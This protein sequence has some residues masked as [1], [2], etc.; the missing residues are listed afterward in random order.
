MAGNNYQNG[1]GWNRGGSGNGGSRGYSNQPPQQ[2]YGRPGQA[3]LDLKSIQTELTKK[4][5]DNVS[6]LPPGFNRDRFILN[7]ITFIQ[8][9]L[10]DSKKRENLANVDPG[11]IVAC[12]MKGA[13]LGLDFFNGECYAIP[14]GS[15]MTFQTDYKGEIKLNKMYSK[16]PI[17]DIF[18]KVVREG[19]E[20]YEE[21]SGGEQTIYYRP[22]PFS[23]APLVGAF[24]VVKYK[25]GS[26][27]YESMS[28]E[29]IEK[30]RTTYSKAANSKAWK[31]ST[32]EMYKKT[33]LRRVCKFVD[34]DFTAE[35]RRA[36]EDGGDAQFDDVIT[37]ENRRAIENGGQTVNVFQE[38]PKPAAL[39]EPKARPAAPVVEQKKPEPVKAQTAAAPPDDDF[40]RFEQSYR[41]S[42][43]PPNDDYMIP[44][45]SMEGL[46]FR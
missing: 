29:E 7:C 36:F 24:A 46:P 40:A 27:L 37:V 20:F 28:A 33:V 41:E 10:A 16:N 23:T 13:V 26:M 35:Q 30:V 18:A 43:Q 25:D 39:P 2:G 12:F 22:V 4:L 38:P 34:L 6:A 17:R 15:Q 11:S 31:E 9:I 19:D 3:A 42:A 14:Y 8:D 5:A 44:D 21:V 32:G 1:N 45:D